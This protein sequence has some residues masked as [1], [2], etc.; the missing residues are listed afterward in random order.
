MW[1]SH[2]LRSEQK[3]LV[4]CFNTSWSSGLSRA[5]T[6]LRIMNQSSHPPAVSAAF[7][8]KMSSTASSK[9][10]GTSICLILKVK[11]TAEHSGNWRGISAL[12]CGG[13][14]SDPTDVCSCGRVSGVSKGE[15][16]WKLH[17]SCYSLFAVSQVFTSVC[18]SMYVFWNSSLGFKWAK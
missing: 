18:V 6:L 5:H 2:F 14:L 9:A 7:P 1:S 11:L 17:S 3:A 13:H 12:V 4:R 8:I 16:Q 10:Q 15:I